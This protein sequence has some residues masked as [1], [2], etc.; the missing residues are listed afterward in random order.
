MELPG[1][2]ASD[3]EIR[4]VADVRHG[5][6]V[7]MPRGL[8]TVLS[9]QYFAPGEH[10]LAPLPRHWGAHRIVTTRGERWAGQGSTVTVYRPKIKASSLVTA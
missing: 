6:Q 5:E 3:L 1:Y 2:P 7:V 8:A 9:V 10:F 4:A